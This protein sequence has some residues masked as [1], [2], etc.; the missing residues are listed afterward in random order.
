MENDILDYLDY[1]SYEK[2]LSENTKISY[3]SDLMAYKAFLNQKHIN[4][5]DKVKKENIKDYFMYLTNEK[6]TSTTLARKLTAIKTFH[7]YLVKEN[8]IQVDVSE[9]I[10]RPKL[11]KKL[12]QVMSIEEI[13]KLLD[14]QIHNEFDSRNK[15]MLELLYATGIRVSELIHLTLHSIDLENCVIRLIGKG[16]KERIVPIG[17]YTMVYLKEYLKVR[18]KL[19]KNTTTEYL[20]LNNHGKGMTRQGFFKILKKLLKEKGLNENISPHT[21][22]HS[23][24]THLL[25]Y[26]A[27][28]RSIQLMLGHS[29]IATTKI[30]THITGDKIKE[31]YQ[32]YHPRE[33]K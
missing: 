14:I 8:R 16:N 28:L 24:A 2:G 18:H 15:A 23:F 11:R 19:L 13:A 4:T 10:E 26:G 17:E 7:K 20:F 12:P 33:H 3:K 5:W 31:E 27:D 6:E 1:I 30:Y 22:R 29:D 21:L 25:N 9:N 32:K